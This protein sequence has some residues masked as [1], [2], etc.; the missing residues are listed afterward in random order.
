MAVNPIFQCQCGRATGNP[1][2]KNLDP[3][4]EH[5]VR[6]FFEAA[7]M[8]R[9]RPF[10]GDLIELYICRECSSKEIQP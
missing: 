6:R 10:M 4:V 3:Y 7:I 8:G 1:Q 2:A 9:P 5:R